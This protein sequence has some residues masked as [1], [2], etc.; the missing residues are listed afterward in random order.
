MSTD[1]RL[2]TQ[3]AGPD[4]VGPSEARKILKVGKARFNQLTAAPGFPDH[5]QLEIG[6]VWWR[7]DIRAFQLDRTDQRRRTRLAAIVSYR[8]SGNVAHA[9]RTAGVD[10]STLRRWLRELDIPLPRDEDPR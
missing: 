4:V 9:A 10:P 1:P 7:T 5:T 8:R 3:V 6:R 2:R